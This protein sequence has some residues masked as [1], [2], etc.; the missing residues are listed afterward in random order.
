MV[1]DQ[2][3]VLE[4][5]VSSGNIVRGA[6]IRR[7]CSQTGWPE[8][9]NIAFP[10]EEMTKSRG[11]LWLELSETESG[12]ESSLC[13]EPGWGEQHSSTHGVIQPH[14]RQEIALWGCSEP[15]GSERLGQ[16]MSLG[17]INSRRYMMAH[18]PLPAF[19]TST[20]RF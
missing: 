2:G 16:V 14:W 4:Y 1:I 13:A 17:N 10:H 5:R 20:E 11:W 6:E 8:G 12:L 18:V 9:K 3:F 19:V 7:L 15:N